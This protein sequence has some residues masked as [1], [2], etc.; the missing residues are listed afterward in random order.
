MNI[1]K[2]LKDYLSYLEIERGRSLKTVKNYR[3]YLE[4][5]FKIVGIKT[6]KDID[7]EKVKQFRLFLARKKTRQGFLKKN[8]QSY[9]IIGLR[10]F[11]KFLIKQDFKVLSPD[12][13][14]LPKSFPRQIELLTYDELL[15]LL[16]A[17]VNDNLKSLR[18]KA[19]LETLFCTGLRVSELCS[20]NRYFD[21]E[22]GEISIRGKG[23]T[24][25]LVFLSEKAKKTLK[26]Y[27]A[28]RT[29]Q[30]QA[31]FVSLTHS[32]KPK[33]IGRL[34]SRTAER[35]INFYAKKA[36]IF[37]KVSPHLLRHEFATDLLMSGADLR[38][39][40]E[41]LGHKSIST[42]QIYTHL[43]N[44]QLKKIHQKYHNQRRKK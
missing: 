19:I 4:T 20:L 29:D 31:L 41:L 36:G 25:R 6:E 32:Q 28:K 24:I 34:T 18:D 39:V 40:Q 30:E 23:E 16:E 42:T 33:V 43:T 11:L 35:I 44:P 14:D 8:T 7:L 2:L 15:R 37:K 22:K 27:L 21:L 10:N 9:Y 13:I 1:Y 12:K 17:P 3:Y 5:F 38:S 26:T